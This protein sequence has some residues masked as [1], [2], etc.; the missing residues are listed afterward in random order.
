[1]KLEDT[2]RYCMK[3]SILAILVLALAACTQSSDCYRDEILCAALVTDTNGLKDDGI[4]QDLWAGL[5]HSRADGV[6]DQIAYIES[7]DIRDYEKNIAFFVATGYDVIITSG[8]GMRDA[9]LYSA[10]LNAEPNPDLKFIGMSQSFASPLPNL[11]QVTFPEDKMGF[12]AGAIAARITKTKIVGAVCETSGIDAM[13][14]YCEGFRAGVAY[15]DETI[16]PR[17]VYRDRGSRD[18]LFIDEE[19][20]SENAKILIQSG[21]DVIFAVGGGTGVGALRATSDAGIP[22]IGAERDQGAA[23]GDDGLEVVT[24]ILG[25]SDTA[26]QILMRTLKDGGQIESMEYPIRYT[27]LNTTL[28]NN[29]IVELNEILISLESGEIET[30]VTTQRP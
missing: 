18:L 8:N 11:I 9:T 21:A 7:V 19:W 27:P 12:L 23:L 16:D 25:Q 20:G 14:R 13:W 2:L 26:I 10:E 3:I 28:Q 1:M 30:N 22:A 29:E 4:T 5:E 17:I 24:S 6:V 15:V